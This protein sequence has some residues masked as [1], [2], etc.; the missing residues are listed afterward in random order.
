ML[1]DNLKKE[2]EFVK[3]EVIH[4]VIKPLLD[5]YGY[6][7]FINDAGGSLCELNESSVIRQLAEDTL[8]V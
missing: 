8:I 1:V 4:H 7:Y 6:P 3:S 5:T 2:L